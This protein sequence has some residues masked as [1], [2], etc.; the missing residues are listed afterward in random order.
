M[1]DGAFVVCRHRPPDRARI[2]SQSVEF[3]SNLD[4]LP[5]GCCALIS[6]PRSGASWV[7]IH[8][9]PANPVRPV[10]VSVARLV[11]KLCRFCC[12]GSLDAGYQE[13]APGPQ[14]DATATK[15]SW[16]TPPTRD[17]SDHADPSDS[18]A[19]CGGG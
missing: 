17:A 14:V 9:P 16:V 8:D 12:G 1:A 10:R 15:V 6:D 18:L 11:A 5:V 4:V 13:P 2:V 3:Q 19:D 7:E